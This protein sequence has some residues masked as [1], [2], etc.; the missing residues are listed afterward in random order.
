MNGNTCKLLLISILLIIILIPFPGISQAGMEKNQSTGT[1]SISGVV[2]DKTVE[3]N[4]RACASIGAGLL[5]YRVVFKG[6]VADMWQ[7]SSWKEGMLLE[8]CSRTSR[9]AW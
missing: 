6:Y 9:K 4:G 3:I 2:F 8:K 7:P 1:I 5:R